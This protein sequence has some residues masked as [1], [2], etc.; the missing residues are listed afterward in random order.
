[1]RKTIKIYLKNSRLLFNIVA[2]IIFIYLKFSYFTS[3]WIFITPKDF[4]EQNLNDESG[5]FFALWHNRLA[6]SMYIFRNYKNIF[7]LTSPHSDGKII[8][9]LVLM[10]NYKIIEGS[11][12]KNS[13]SAVKEIIKQ[14][15]NG[16][17]IVI[18]PDGPRGP[19]Y[20]NG[21]VITKIASKYKKKVIPVSCH[22]SR[23]FEV[24]SWDKMML[25]KPFSKIIVVIG[26]PLELSGNDE[27]DRLLLEKKLNNLASQTKDLY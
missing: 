10:M 22:A 11:T 5:L 23:Y 6:Y 7:G 14:I 21:S 20:K 4:D 26:E 17:K 3:K 27:Y 24:K 25:P 8:G 13:N 15:T 12:N 9:K 19:V 1:M 18:T 2:V 16:A